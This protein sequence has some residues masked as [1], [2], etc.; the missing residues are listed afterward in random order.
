V[1]LLITYLWILRIAALLVALT[2]LMSLA[3][4]LA[5]HFNKAYSLYRLEFPRA[6]S[7]V[8]YIGMVRVRNKYVRE[9][10]AL[11]EVLKECNQDHP[12]DRIAKLRS[13][14]IDFPQ[15]EYRALRDA[16]LTG[17]IDNA[18]SLIRQR[19]E[20][21]L[22][23]LIG[24]LDEEVVHNFALRNVGFEI[25]EAPSKRLQFPPLD[26]WVRE[27]DLLHTRVFIPLLGL[28]SSRPSQAGPPDWSTGTIAIVATDEERADLE[29]AAIQLKDALLSSG[30]DSKRSV[31]ALYR[32]LAEMRRP[33][34]ERSRLLVL[35][36]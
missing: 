35:E 21:T 8:T 6:I 33:N 14:P 25:V 12:L 26:G 4:S 2:V 27:V 34:D 7:V 10:E 17:S 23:S 36:Q 5:G 9:L 22:T 15:A 16:I 3:F 24:L 30:F 29:D 18:S 32:G 31:L 1:S 19:G 11:S 20:Q 13:L 28:T